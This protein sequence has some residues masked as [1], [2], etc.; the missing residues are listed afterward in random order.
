MADVT[1]LSHAN[2]L[3]QKHGKLS[4]VMRWYQSFSSNESRGQKMARGIWSTGW[5]TFTGIGHVIGAGIENSPTRGVKT[6]HQTWGK[7]QDGIKN[8]LLEIRRP[9]RRAANRR[10]EGKLVC[11]TEL[12]EQ[13]RI[14]QKSRSVISNLSHLLAVGGCKRKNGEWKSEKVHGIEDGRQPIILTYSGPPPR[15]D[16]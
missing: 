2:R 12:S 11:K 3:H 15:K 6:R 7:Y 1:G 9:S 8:R 13:R 5:R 16:L 10:R 4:N 14:T